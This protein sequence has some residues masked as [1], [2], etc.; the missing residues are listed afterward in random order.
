MK[1][2]TIINRRCE[3]YENVLITLTS[4]M[5]QMRLHLSFT[6]IISWSLRLSLTECYY[7]YYGGICSLYVAL[8]FALF[9][10]YV[11]Y[12]NTLCTRLKDTIYTNVIYT[13]WNT[14]FAIFTQLKYTICT[15]CTIGDTLFTLFALLKYTICTIYTVERHYLHY[16][17]YWFTLLTLSSHLIRTISTI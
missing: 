1:L 3:Y 5:W 15:N 4:V 17:H 12:W 8:L 2:H 13:S 16:L 14:L 6:I 7:C 11:H 10:H 9:R